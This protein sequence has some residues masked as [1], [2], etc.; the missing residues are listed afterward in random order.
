MILRSTSLA[1]ASPGFSLVEVMVATTVFVV[2]V[3]GVAPLFILAARATSGARTTTYTAVLAQEKMEQLRA[4]RWGFDAFD[5]P[6]SDLSTDTSAELEASAGGTGLS[7]SPGDALARNTSGYCDFL[8][9]NG[10]SL[11]GGTAAPAGAVFVRRWS[12]ATLASNTDQAIVIQV[13]VIRIRNGA[14]TMLPGATRLP[15][16]ARFVSL[17]TRKAL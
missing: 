13:L 17:K 16:E 3:V 7:P 5:Q 6:V 12:I 2:G 10:R 8:D 14:A 15:D 4:L 9:T 1:D 11:G